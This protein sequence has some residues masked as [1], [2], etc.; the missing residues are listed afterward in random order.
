MCATNYL[1]P[2]EINCRLDSPLEWPSVEIRA[3]FR[4]QIALALKE[5]LQNVVKHSGASEATLTLRQVGG[6]LVIRVTDNGS[7]LPP[8]AHSSH[9]NGLHNMCERL[10]SIGGSCEIRNLPEGGAEVEMRAPLPATPPMEYP[11]F[12]A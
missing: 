7:G 5:A 3:Q 2:L 10:A 12:E 8:E 11:P 4:H 1:G 6:H 9:R